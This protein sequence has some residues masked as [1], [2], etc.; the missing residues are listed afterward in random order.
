[1]AAISRR[2]RERR[3]HS[4]STLRQRRAVVSFENT[5]GTYLLK[6]ED[7]YVTQ[8]SVQEAQA[9]IEGDSGALPGI[10]VSE[11]RSEENKLDPRG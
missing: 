7:V 4:R 5:K 2:R 10:E 1:M 11:I 9:S 6:G 3:S 8:R